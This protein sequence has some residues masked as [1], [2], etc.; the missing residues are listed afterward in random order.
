MYVQSFPNPGDGGIMFTVSLAPLS[1]AEHKLF[2]R[3]STNANGVI[4]IIKDVS[5]GF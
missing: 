4:I 3:S 1:R 2:R 5:A